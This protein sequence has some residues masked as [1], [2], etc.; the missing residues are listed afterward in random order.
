MAGDSNEV[1]D[2]ASDYLGALKGISAVEPFA[3]DAL[4]DGG[5]LVTAK[6]K[7]NGDDSWGW[8]FERG[9][10]KRAFFA[11]EELAQYISASAIQRTFLGRLLD[12]PP[13]ELIKATVVSFLTFM[14]SVAVI[15]IVIS[16]P[17]NRSLQVLNGLLGL[18]IGYLV[19]KGDRTHGA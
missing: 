16:M 6:L 18:T 4:P 17:D 13:L 9:D 19:G 5:T 10:I 8:Y 1:R 11:P 12:A 3:I 14:F 2:R 15:Y 7:N